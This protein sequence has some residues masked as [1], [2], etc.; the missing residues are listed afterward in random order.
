ML[1]SKTFTFEASH[2]LPKHPGKCAKVHGHSFRLTV[3][4]EGLVVPITG[5]VADYVDLKALVNKLIIDNVDHAHLGCGDLTIADVGAL[6]VQQV[7]PAVLGRDFYPSS[8]NLVVAFAKLLQPEI[9]KL[10]K[11][12]APSY[13]PK[14]HSIALN[15]TCTSECIWLAGSVS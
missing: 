2:V 8:E 14:L 9:P 13:Q 12:V 1:I 3:T 7:Y 5:F 15:E 10:N 4:I 11:D 6:Y